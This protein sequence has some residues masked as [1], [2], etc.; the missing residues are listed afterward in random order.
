MKNKIQSI[1]D[2][3]I[4]ILTTAHLIICL[5]AYP[6]LQSFSNVSALKHSYIFKGNWI[7]MHEQFNH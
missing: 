3:Y 1:S 6:L 2:L 4:L 5:D 7:A